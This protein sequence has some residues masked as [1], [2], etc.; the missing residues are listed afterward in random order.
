LLEWTGSGMQMA[1]NIDQIPLYR[2]PSNSS[3]G[4]H[5]DNQF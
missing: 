3:F 1:I 4:K 5:A 2:R